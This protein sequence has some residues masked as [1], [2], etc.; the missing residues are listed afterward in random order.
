MKVPL[1]DAA[2]SYR[3]PLDGRVCI[4]LIKNALFVASMSYNL[5]PPFMMREAGIKLRD[6]RD[7]W[8]TQRKTTMPLFFRKWICD[9]HCH[10]GAPSHTSR[11]PS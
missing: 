6:V 3:S 11:H 4:L 1:V 9:F 7:T 10:S 8:M 5:I 2:V